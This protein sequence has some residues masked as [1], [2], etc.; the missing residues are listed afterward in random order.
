MIDINTA[1][2]IAEIGGGIA[3]LVSLVYVGYQVRQTNV[4]A[5]AESIRAMQNTDFLAQYNMAIIGRGFNDFMSLNYDEKWEFHSYFIRFFNHYQMVLESRDRGLVTDALADN[6]IKAVAEVVVTTGVQQYWQ[7][8]ARDWFN[9]ES[10]NV[11]EDYIESNRNSIIPYNKK[12][13]WI[14]SK[15]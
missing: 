10:I 3:I 1:A 2:N 15:V 11:L 8:G 6:W 4:H 9:G 5:E 13:S 7:D 12:T 14:S